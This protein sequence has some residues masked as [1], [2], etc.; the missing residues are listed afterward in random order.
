M[1]NMNDTE[2]NKIKE[3][4]EEQNVYVIASIEGKGCHIGRFKGFSLDANKQLIIEV[5]IDEKSC[6]A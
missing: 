6:T 1:K 4:L 3:K 5:D 2:L